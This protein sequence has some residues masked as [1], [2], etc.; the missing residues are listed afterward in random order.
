M[1]I[2]LQSQ[3]AELDFAVLGAPNA[4]F[5]VMPLTIKLS[6]SF[7]LIDLS[8]VALD[9]ALQRCAKLVHLAIIL[10]REDSLLLSQLAVK[11]Q[12]QR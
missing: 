11:L 10:R 5:L 7:Q 9:F 2:V 4:D 12:P 3:Q 6:K 1:K 8:I